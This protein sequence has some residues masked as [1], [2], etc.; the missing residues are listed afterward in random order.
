MSAMSDHRMHDRTE[1]RKRALQNYR[2]GMRS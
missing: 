1:Q 2:Q